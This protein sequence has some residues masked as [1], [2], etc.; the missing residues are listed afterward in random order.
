[1][2]KGKLK[3]LR[4][5]VKSF[6]KE[7]KDYQLDEIT[8]SKIQEWIQFHKLDIESLKS[9]YSEDYYQKK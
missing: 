5:N 7:F 6:F 1:M 3:H 2:I 9:E 4:D 8:D